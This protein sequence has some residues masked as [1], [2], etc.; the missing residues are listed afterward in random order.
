MYTG[1]TSRLL[2][3]P[4][5]KGRGQARDRAW[6]DRPSPVG[7]RNSPG[8]WSPIRRVVEAGV[9]RTA[10]LEEAARRMGGRPGLTGFWRVVMVLILHCRRRWLLSWSRC[11]SRARLVARAV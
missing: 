3:H 9:G 6:A 11:R 2:G 4:A 5:S 7:R 1:R 8:Y 10:L